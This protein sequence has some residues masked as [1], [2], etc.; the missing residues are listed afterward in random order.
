M[1]HQSSIRYGFVAGT[2]GATAPVDPRLALHK[3]RHAENQI[4]PIVHVEDNEWF[5]RVEVVKFD[6]QREENLPRRYNRTSR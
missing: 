4:V 1:T 6:R 2:D 3:P 5:N